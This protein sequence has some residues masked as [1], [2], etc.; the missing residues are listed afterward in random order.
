MGRPATDEE[1]ADAVGADVHQIGRQRAAVS[2]AR[3]LSLDTTAVQ[4]V[5]DRMPSEQG[6]IDL[7]Q[8][9]NV[10]M[11][12]Q[13]MTS[14]SDRDRHVLHLRYFQGLSQQQIAHRIGVS[15]M[16][17][18]RNLRNILTQLRQDLTDQDT[19]MPTMTSTQLAG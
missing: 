7:E 16:H 14:L 15:Q 3:A 2:G 18:S 17:V 6:H 13:V 12:R 19:P 4:A 5:I 11:I 1:L 10:I 8:A 9:E